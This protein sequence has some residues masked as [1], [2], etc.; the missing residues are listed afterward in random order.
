MHQNST[1]MFNFHSEQSEI[2]TLLVAI[3]RSKNFYLLTNKTV[4]GCHNTNEKY[5]H[6]IYKHFK[7]I[8]ETLQ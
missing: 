3:Q 8:A 5:D 1:R 2:T 6:I 7:E 4:I